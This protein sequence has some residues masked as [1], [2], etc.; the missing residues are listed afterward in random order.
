MRLLC[1]LL[2]ACLFLAQPLA[3]QDAPP[4]QVNKSD[5]VRLL[6]RI[7]TED[8]VRN[9]LVRLGFRGQNLSL[10]T[11]QMQRIMA[12]PVVAGYIADQVLAFNADGTLPGAD[13]AR[14]TLWSVID[15]GVGH[16]PIRDLRYFYL[17]EQTVL[18]A[19][20]VRD[21]G[22]VVKNRLSPARLSDTTA[23]VA[24]RLNTPALEQYYRI[25]LDA[26]R[27]GATRPPITM[28]AARI[29]QIETR[30][31]NAL[32]ARLEGAENGA[33]MIR[34]FVRLDKADNRSACAAGRLFIDTV[35]NMQGRDQ[36][37][38]LILL[39]IP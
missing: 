13:G 19:M 18:N 37:D 29:E 26:A 38:A 4:P 39:S 5:I 36:H 11:A 21:C 3:A 20:P 24:A 7:F 30:I 23:R 9:D 27:F 34:T 33:H 14:G 15:N 6:G 32:L 8:T 12:D 35:M 16:L 1:C 25:Q 22:L 2:T 31:F 17:V 10:A 28:S